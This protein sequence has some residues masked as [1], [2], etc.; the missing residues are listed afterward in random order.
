MKTNPLTNRI[1]KENGDRQALRW[2]QADALITSDVMA[3]CFEP[4]LWSFHDG[5][6]ATRRQS[7]PR[8]APAPPLESTPPLL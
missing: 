1:V 7:S 3:S 8:V 6:R 4:V 2:A 5:F